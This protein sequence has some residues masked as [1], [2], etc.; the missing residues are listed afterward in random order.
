M[1]Y[2]TPDQWRGTALGKAG[3]DALRAAVGAHAGWPQHRAD[4]GLSHT[5]DLTTAEL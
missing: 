4:L 1:T 2:Y 3:R 5:G